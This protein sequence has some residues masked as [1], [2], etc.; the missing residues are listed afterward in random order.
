MDW[1]AAQVLEVHDRELKAQ[2]E[3]ILSEIRR[4]DEEL[5]TQVARFQELSTQQKMLIDTLSAERL[6]AQEKFEGTVAA[7][8]VQQNEFRQSLDDLGKE[9]ATRRELEAAL[10]SIKDETATALKAANAKGDERARQLVDLRSRMDTGALAGQA[11]GYQQRGQQINGAV[12]AWAGLALAAVAIAIT[13][14]AK[15]A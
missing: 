15:F 6:R 3:L 1:T 5:E 4:L 13:L 14:I 2:K 7:R 12:I 10:K 9:M 11:L 8:F